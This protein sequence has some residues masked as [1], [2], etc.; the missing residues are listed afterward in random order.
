MSATP[1]GETPEVEVVERLVLHKYE[2]DLTEEE[3]ETAQPLET[4]VIERGEI[5]EHTIHSEE[6]GS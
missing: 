5:V 3:M 2:G 1:P 4:L 6:G